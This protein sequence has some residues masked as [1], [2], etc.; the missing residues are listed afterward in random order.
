MRSCTGWIGYSGQGRPLKAE[1]SPT[2]TCCVEMECSPNRHGRD[3]ASH[4]KAQTLQVWK[5]MGSLA[6]AFQHTPVRAA[7]GVREAQ[8]CLRAVGTMPHLP[9]HCPAP[10]KGKIQDK[11]SG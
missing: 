4:T 8:T 7:E 6:V 9:K 10:P 2:T 3:Q 11:L 5:S 1:Q